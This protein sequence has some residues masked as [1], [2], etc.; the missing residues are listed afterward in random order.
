MKK[1]ISVVA[2]L[3]LSV[4]AV[5]SMRNLDSGKSAP[6]R[7]NVPNGLSGLSDSA[8]LEIMHKMKSSKD[9]RHFLL[10]DKVTSELGKKEFMEKYSGE[11]I[12]KELIEDYIKT[13]QIPKHP[14]FEE[15]LELWLSTYP[16]T[17]EFIRGSRDSEMAYECFRSFYD[18]QNAVKDLNNARQAGKQ[19]LSPE[20]AAVNFAMLRALDKKTSKGEIVPVGKRLI[21]YL[22]ANGADANCV[23]SNNISAL[24]NA[25]KNGHVAAV[26]SLINCGADVNHVNVRNDGHLRRTPF[27][28]GDDKYTALMY[29]AENGHVAVVESLLNHGADLNAESFYK[30]TALMKAGRS[31]S[32]EIIENFVKRGADIQ[33]VNNKK[34]NLLLIA[35]S[36]GHKGLIEYLTDKYKDD[37]GVQN[38]LNHQNSEGKTALMIAAKK[39]H[40]AI[41]DYLLDHGADATMRTYFFGASDALYEA[42]TGGSIEVIESLLRHGENIKR[43]Y[44]N[45]SD[46]LMAAALYGHDK[47]VEYLI[48]THK[49]DVKGEDY[50]KQTALIY[51]AT[52][53]KKCSVAE[54]LLKHG[55][56]VNH[57]DF[58]GYSV[59]MNAVFTTGRIDYYKEDAQFIKFLLE[60]GADVNLRD[61]KG[62]TIVDHLRENDGLWQYVREEYRQIIDDWI[63]EHAQ[64]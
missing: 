61:S 46:I 5:E 24:A 39:G 35:A 41:V 43:A 64:H 2:V 13:Y 7:F 17:S 63:A 8:K 37:F 12:A 30:E 1:F 57:R 54:I 52:Y 59:L 51:A 3:T 49:F 11:T 53:S 21:D 10:T 26:E 22:L 33:H 40:V 9:V 60:H 62:M 32:I 29:A 42:V 28:Y 19:D 6:V 44:A 56:D 16:E 25:A 58:R 31:G 18:A 48:N 45:G 47:L 27:K 14:D 4:Y 23:D 15:K 38:Y 36:Y 50:S 34:D 55:A 20:I